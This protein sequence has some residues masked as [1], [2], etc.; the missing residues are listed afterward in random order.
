M[1]SM[2]SYH[3]KII[4]NQKEADLFLCMELFKY[5]FVWLSKNVWRS[6]MPLV[7]DIYRNPDE[8][9][10]P[11]RHRLSIIT[12]WVPPSMGCIKI[13]VDGPFYVDLNRIGI[14]RLFHDHSGNMLIH[15]TK[16]VIIDSAIFM[17]IHA[18]QKDLHIARSCFSLSI[19]F[20]IFARV[21]FCQYCH[22]VQGPQDCLVE[23]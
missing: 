19:I 21:R 16:F 2:W 22:L 10:V 14:G 1:C 5:Y 12:C 3:N 11:P 20:S 18:I 4:Y 13:N 8:V 23:V 7:T 15:F 17:K 6:V 9:F